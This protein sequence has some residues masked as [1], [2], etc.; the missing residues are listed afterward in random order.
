M[1]RLELDSI[2]LLLNRGE[3]D[4]VVGNHAPVVARDEAV[5]PFRP[6]RADHD[7]RLI[8]DQNAADVVDVFGGGGTQLIPIEW[9]IRRQTAEVHAVDLAEFKIAQHLQWKMQRLS[10]QLAPALGGQSDAYLVLCHLDDPSG[11]QQY[12]IRIHAHQ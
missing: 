10:G 7:G 3:C 11:C 1:I 2:F 5:M 12:P 4:P 6:Q 9:A 8:A